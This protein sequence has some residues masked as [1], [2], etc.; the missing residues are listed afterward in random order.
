MKELL[1][2]IFI[3]TCGFVLISIISVIYIKYFKTNS[4][5]Q[6]SRE[7]KEDCGQYNQMTQEAE[8]VVEMKKAILLCVKGEING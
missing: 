6:Q 1:A 5:R 7:Q 8:R 4:T 3:F 2:L